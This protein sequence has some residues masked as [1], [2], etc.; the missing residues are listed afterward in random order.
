VDISDATIQ[1]M[2]Y[3]VSRKA[4]A[5]LL[6]VLA[7]G[8]A[9]WVVLDI[10]FDTPSPDT[11]ADSALARALRRHPNTTL[12]GQLSDPD[13]ATNRT[14]SLK[15]LK[16]RESVR[17]MDAFLT[18]TPRWGVVLNKQEADGVVRRYR[19]SWPDLAGRPRLALGIRALTDAGWLDSTILLTRP[20][21]H[22]EGFR[23]RFCG[24]SH[25]F[26]Y[27]A[28]ETVLDDSAWTSRSEEDWG[29]HLDL[30]DSLVRAG[31][32]KDRIV[33][34]GA[35]AKTLQDIY[36]I[37]GRGNLSMPGVELH[38]HAMATLLTRSSLQDLPRSVLWLLFLAWTALVLWRLRRLRE[39]WQQPV[40]TVLFGL[41]WS[42]LAVACVLSVQ[43]ILPVALGWLACTGSLLVASTERYLDEADRKREI[44]RTF[45]QYVS[46]DVV[47]MMIADPSKVVMGGSRAEISVLFSD[48]QGFTGISERQEPERLVQQL[49]DALT[50]LSQR[51]LDAGGTLDK[52]MGDAIMAE[53]GMPLPQAD[54][55]L[56]ACKAALDMQAELVRLRPQWQREG[57]AE[58]HM[59][60]GVATGPAIFGNLGSRQKFDFTALGDTVNLS[61]R[62]EGLNKRFGTSI[63]IDSNT[64]EQAGE[65]I[66]VRSLGA[67]A[68]PGKQEPVEVWELLSLS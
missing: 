23:I 16:T 26:P 35:S 13:L 27:H 15:V 51:I 11:A 25:S 14:S 60:I 33:L 36:K 31:V 64:R 48:F 9:R 37:P 18:S 59:R 40:V 24:T 38:A 21:N 6:D 66:R 65:A 12:S 34:V 42:A 44:T 53:F 55:A 30:G 68:V 10:V 67:V 5:H 52:F 19:P 45:G 57:L 58:L 17:P 54:K 3:P 41:A 4:Y 46:P 2:G 8:G 63:L 20:W 61:S 22:S 62:L 28:L 7:R 56:R 39:W 32:F 50:Q 49:G 47:K 1:E 43:V 29:E